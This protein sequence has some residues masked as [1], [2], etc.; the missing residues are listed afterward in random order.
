MKTYFLRSPF[1]Y[2]IA[3]ALAAVIGLGLQGPVANNSEPAPATFRTPEAMR[4]TSHVDH[5]PYVQTVLDAWRGRAPMTRPPVVAQPTSWRFALGDSTRGLTVPASAMPSN[6]EPVTLRHRLLT[7]SMPMWYVRELLVEEPLIMRVS[8]DDGAQVYVDGQRLYQRRPYTYLLRPAPEPQEVRIRVLNN[9]IFGGLNRVRLYRA[10]AYANYRAQQRLRGR[11]D[12]L[13]TKLAHW[14]TPERRVAESITQ[15]VAEPTTSHV[16]TAEAQ[17]CDWPWIVAG[18]LVQVPQ[19]GVRSIVWETDCPGS[20][21]LQWGTAPD[22]LDRHVPGVD[23]AGVHEALLTNLPVDRTIYYRVRA[24]S[25]HSRTYRL[26][27]PRRTEGGRAKPPP[28]PFS[29]TAWGDPQNGWPAF[30]QVIHALR[31]EP[32]A[33]SIGLGDYVSNGS[34]ARSWYQ[35]WRTLQPLAARVPVHL[36]AGN[37]DYDGFYDDMHPKHFARYVRNGPH[38][39]YKAWSY[40]NARFVALDPNENFPVFIKPGS[41]QHRWLQQELQSSEW[42]EATWR[43]LIVH[44]PPYAEMSA[45][46]DG[47]RSV[48]ALTDTLAAV[49]K[50]DFVLSGH[51]HD[52]ERW[53]RTLDGHTTHYLTLGGAGGP[54]TSDTRTKWPRVDV[55]ALRHHYGAF[56]VNGDTVRVRAVPADRGEPL[57]AF[58]AIRDTTRSPGS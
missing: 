47:Y 22:A 31:D 20:S 1:L 57:D 51:N 7:P 16:E 11:I 39:G 32:Q 36:V 21:Q 56:T 52:Y 10:E 43:F 53:S 42:T 23:S 25:T 17:F 30:R 44:Q 9:A 28:T 35:F 19:P 45:A 3:L 40:G 15:A 46:W 14:R 34:V 2:G 24:G 54:L 55:T 58:T 49:H 12:T 5:P 29:F 48:R 33:F 41:P 13:V 26:E 37:H 18:P 50:I 8:A 6:T 4:P 38:L 27:A